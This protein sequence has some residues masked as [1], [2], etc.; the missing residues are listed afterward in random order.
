MSEIVDEEFDAAYSIIEETHRSSLHRAISYS[1]YGHENNH[2]Q[3]RYLA[4]DTLS[5]N[6]DLFQNYFYADEANPSSNYIISHLNSLRQ[7]GTFAGQ[8]Y[9]LAQLY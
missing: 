7:P 5:Q 6:I 8:E 2:L 9:L 3:L 1:L 4:V